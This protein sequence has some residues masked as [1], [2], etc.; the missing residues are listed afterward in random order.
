MDSII[1][2]LT[3]QASSVGSSTW[4]DLGPVRLFEEFLHSA[5]SLTLEVINMINKDSSSAS[6]AFRDI[7]LLMVNNSSA[8]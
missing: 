1:K 4:N 3:S 8:A 5:V 6:V 2:P 7:N